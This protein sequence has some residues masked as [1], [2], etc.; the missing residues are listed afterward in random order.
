VS[1]ELP[2]YISI[3]QAAEV[4]GVCDKTIRRH[5]AAGHLRA[6]R[7]GKRLIRVRVEDIE[8]LLR[9]IPSART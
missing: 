4:L 1:T 5:I 6:Y 7:C 9:E 2:V 8:K 3:P